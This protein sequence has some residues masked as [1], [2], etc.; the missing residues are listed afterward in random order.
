MLQLYRLRPLPGHL[1]FRLYQAFI[2][3]FFDYCDVV[4]APTMV[5]LSKPLERLH[6]RFLQ[7]VP[8]SN[9]FVFLEF[10]IT[11]V[12]DISEIGLCILRHIQDC[13]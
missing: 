11:S 1:L 2:L 10:S 3:P 12:R 13:L 7:R 8:F 6:S 5:S 4:W 9:S